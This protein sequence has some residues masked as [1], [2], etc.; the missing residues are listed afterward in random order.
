MTETIKLI[1][2]RFDKTLP[3]P[4]YKTSGAAAIDLYS[5]L[6]LTIAPHSIGY[7]PL[8]IALKLPKKYF[9]L[10]TARSSLH[11]QGLMMANGVGVGDSDYC[12]DGDEYQAALYNFTSKEVT[13]E[14]GQRLVQL[15][16]LPTTKLTLVEKIKFTTKNRGGFGSTGK[17]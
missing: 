5:R 13:V 4:E 16:V 2:K 10:I 15:M 17:K 6:D 9:A 3:L 7:A 14:R 8:N 12:G 11:K 1:I